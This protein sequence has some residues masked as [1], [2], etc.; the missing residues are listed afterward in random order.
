MKYLVISVIALFVSGLFAFK[1]KKEVKHQSQQVATMKIGKYISYNVGAT[2]N[3]GKYLYSRND[4]SPLELTE[5]LP[6]KSMPKK[7][8]MVMV[9][10]G[11]GMHDKPASYIVDNMAFPVFFA[12]GGYE[13]NAA[14][15]KQHGYVPFAEK[16]GT[17]LIFLDGIIYKVLIDEDSEDKI[18][19]SS[20]FVTEDF[21]NQASEEKTEKKG[22]KKKKKRK[23]GLGALTNALATAMSDATAKKL[24]RMG[25]AEKLH[26]YYKDAIAK[27]KA[28][29]PTWKKSKEG[30]TYIKDMN[31]KRDLIYGSINKQRMV[32][33]TNKTGRDIYVYTGD[34]TDAGVLAAGTSANYMCGLAYYY[35]FTGK[36]WYYPNKIRRIAF[37]GDGTGCGKTMSIK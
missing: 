2:E 15:Q 34:S 17:T 27:K 30:A 22:K 12:K 37:S 9:K 29:Y 24:M 7:H 4:N 10:I 13:G 26:Q 23:F 19:I 36:R 25:A 35:D 28:I 20:L 16:R 14:I 31:T 1:V 8:K 21:V 18:E 32:T 3:E 11:N 6:E 33:L 5:I